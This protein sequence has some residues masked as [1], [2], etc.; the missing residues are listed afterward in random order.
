MVSNHVLRRNARA[1]LGGGIFNNKWLNMLVACIIPSVVSTLMTTFG[2]GVISFLVTF[3]I[4]YG[5]MRICVRC[6]EG[7]KWSFDNLFDGFKEK[8]GHCVGLGFLQAVYL[9]L[10]TILFFPVGIVKSYS[11][12]MSYYISQ[13]KDNDYS[14][15]ECITKSREM[16]DGYKWQLFCLDFSF[17]GWYILGM[18]CF[19]VGVLFVT[20]YHQVARANFYEALKA[21]E[22]Y[23]RV[24]DEDGFVQEET[25]VEPDHSYDAFFEEASRPSEETEK[26]EEPKEDT[27][28]KNL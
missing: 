21:G 4:T 5:L 22:G 9:F 13:E 27:Y 19:G 14:A 3:P 15:N 10:W 16:M 1:Q 6:V 23:D 17:I 12:A 2:L 25:P 18:L 28:T 11:Y 20:P 8:F 7:R 24:R 26:T